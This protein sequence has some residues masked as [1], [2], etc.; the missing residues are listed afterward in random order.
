[1]REVEVRCATP[2][3]GG[4]VVDFFRR[5]YRRGHPFQSMEYWEWHCDPEGERESYLALADGRVVGHL[6]SNLGGG[7][8][9]V[10]QLLLEESYRG[11]GVV[12]RLYALARMRGSL[13]TTNA[14]AIAHRMYRKMGWIRTCDLQRYVV[15]RAGV[16]AASAVAPVVV[17]AKRFTPP[18]GHYWRQPE[19]IGAAMEGGNVVLQPEVGGAR[20]VDLRDAQALTGALWSAGFRWADYVTSWN[21]PLCTLLEESGWELNEAS[22]VPWRLDPVVPDSVARISVLSEDHLPRELVIRRTY[23]DHGR[24]GSLRSGGG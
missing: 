19:I 16:E 15:T 24:V 20:I 17:D 10:L 13:A 7:L 5:N 4:A 22:A 23:C 6:A 8:V 21:D 14:N 18:R 2:A 3:D 1:M 11:A 9:W 12:R